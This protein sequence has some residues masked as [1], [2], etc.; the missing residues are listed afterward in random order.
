MADG[1]SAAYAA[2]PMYGGVMPPQ[3]VMQQRPSVGGKG[4]MKRPSYDQRESF[5]KDK[6]PKEKKAKKL[7]ED[8]ALV[9]PTPIIAFIKSRKREKACGKC[10]ECKKPP[11]GTCPSC[12]LNKK[13][14]EK[15]RC[16]SLKCEK[17]PDAEP[18]APPEPPKAPAGQAPLPTTME[19]IGNELLIVS[20]DISKFSAAAGQDAET[21]AKYKALLERKSALHAAQ[22]YA[23]ASVS[24]R[25]SKFPVGFS[26][27]WSVINKLEKM[28]SRFAEYVVKQAPGSSSKTVER[29]RD[30]R[31][32]L[33]G[34]I[35]EL[36]SKWSEE[37]CPVDE[38]DA[39][40]FWLLLGKPRS[41]SYM[42]ADVEVFDS[43]DS[44]SD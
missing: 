29:K 40:K 28:R 10:A 39:E 30:K 36:V 14:A 18:V 43:D 11:C 27:P 13:S 34:V 44:D 33:D 38:C 25:K 41:V 37:L 23:R 32:V 3:Q 6:Q 16:E 26:D 19:A 5:G 17:L 2:Y 7:A 12:V 42:D 9:P 22:S 15:R 1:A 24:R 21:R 8:A 4:P 20:L 31:D 35:T